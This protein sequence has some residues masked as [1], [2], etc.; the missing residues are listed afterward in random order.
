MKTATVRQLRH[1]FGSVIRCVEDG[2]SVQLTKRG[3]VIAL[4]QPAPKATKRRKVQWPDFE[5][6]LKRIFGDKVL[7]TTGTEIVAYGRGDR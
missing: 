5:A 1:D 3:R 4:L 7:P 6:R 2:E